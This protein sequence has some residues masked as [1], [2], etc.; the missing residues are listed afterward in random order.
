VLRAAP[1][2]AETGAALM[3]TVFQLA[4]AAALVL[5]LARR[6]GAGPIA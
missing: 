5:V 3:V 4:L 1:R 6:P 2:Q